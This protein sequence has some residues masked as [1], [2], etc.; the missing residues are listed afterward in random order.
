MK[1]THPLNVLRALFA[2]LIA[3]LF[4]PA[5]AHEL[6]IAE[7]ELR[8]LTTSDF[9]WQWSASGK[10]PASEQLTPK[11]PEGC[12]AE[13]QLLRCG[14]EG[15][16]G[17][18]TIEGIG[19]TYSA[20]LV[21]LYW[22]E[23]PFKVYTISSAQKTARIG[24]I[25]QTDADGIASY[26]YLGVEHILL[27]IDHL[28]FVLG[29]LL[30]VGNRWTLVKTITAFTVAHSITLAA[31]TFGIVRVAEAPL[32]ASIALSILFL[33][34]EVA[35]T[36]R[37]QSS[38]TIR[39]PWVVAFAFGLLHGFGFAS[40]LAQI[41]LPEAEIP[42]AL[43]MFNVGVEVGQL[44]FVIGMLLLARS[45]RLLQLERNEM[46]QR[47]PGYVVGSMGAFW[48]LQRVAILLKVIT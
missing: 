38:F 21:K 3:L 36:W 19:K 10:V 37:G 15:L 16:R 22:L 18:L 26:I 11:W 24:G 48:T 1:R 20:V 5:Q 32:N 40:G 7:L 25:G 41:G 44:G 35:R 13:G 31:A 46:L 27:G 29:L 2:L 34:L 33:G 17:K 47:L 23:A 4:G 14:K 43:L 6:S 45:I 39:N 9:L 12:T 42:L 28:L 8:Q 30:L